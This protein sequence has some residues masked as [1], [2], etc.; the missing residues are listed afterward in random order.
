MV[1]ISL[2]TKNILF[3]YYLK[4]KKKFW[5]GVDTREMFCIL[6]IINIKY[7]LNLIFQDAL[8]NPV[9]F[10]VKYVKNS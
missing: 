6:I 4:K 5:N 9:T 8:L 7:N 3:L 1:A 10:V 2:P